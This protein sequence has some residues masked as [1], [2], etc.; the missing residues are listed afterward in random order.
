[1]DWICLLI[2]PSFFRRGSEVLES[3]L[4]K[5]FG[6]DMTEL[7]VVFGDEHKDVEE[8]YAFIRCRNYSDYVSGL[9]SSSAIK[10]VLATYE[11]PVYLSD[12]D[13]RA[14]IESI[15]E[16]D[17]P[18]NLSVGDVVKVKEGYLS[19]LT[20]LV[21]K[22]VGYQKYDVLFSFHTRKFNEEMP[23][24]HLTLVDSIFSHL[25]VPVLTDNLRESGILWAHVTGIQFCGAY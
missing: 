17:I 21:T 15:D 3:E 6:D 20:G 13:V 11:N 25:K 18:C 2:S 12:A 4:E 10:G 7:R 9:M 5:I 23:M 19:G 14:F 24:S 22:D 16:E 1:M 8:F